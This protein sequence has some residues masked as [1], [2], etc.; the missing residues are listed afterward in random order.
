[1]KKYNNTRY[2]SGVWHSN[3]HAMSRC[4]V[5][6]LVFSWHDTR[7]TAPLFQKFHGDSYGVCLSIHHIRGLC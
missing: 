7:A 1:M 2:K 5:L 3:P 6:P 4:R